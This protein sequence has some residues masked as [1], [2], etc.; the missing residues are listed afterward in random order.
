[1][2]ET[3]PQC[4]RADFGPNLAAGGGGEVRGCRRDSGVLCGG[5]APGTAALYLFS[6]LVAGM[7]L[8]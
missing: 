4:L 8:G 6:A 5:R 3:Y 1:M 7:N 2:A